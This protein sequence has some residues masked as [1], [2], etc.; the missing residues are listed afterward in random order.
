M[1][2]FSDGSGGV[3]AP[4]PLADVTAWCHFCKCEDHDT[5]ACPHMEEELDRM[6]AERA[7]REESEP[8]DREDGR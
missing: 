2:A 3:R 7:L 8:M 6:E 4:H 5:C 1:I